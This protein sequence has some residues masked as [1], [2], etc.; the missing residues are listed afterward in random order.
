MP[1]LSVGSFNFN[2]SVWN[3]TSLIKLNLSDVQIKVGSLSAV[4]TFI[5]L[6]KF[7]WP[8][9]FNPISVASGTAADGPS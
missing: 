3:S 1:V 6:K 2:D 9:L 8:Y 4:F 7:F 5:E